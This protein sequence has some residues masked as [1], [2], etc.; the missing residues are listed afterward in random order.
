MKRAPHALIG[1]TLLLALFISACN[2][3]KEDD[4]NVHVIALTNILE[5]GRAAPNQAIDEYQQYLV[6]NDVEISLAIQ[7]YEVSTE[8]MSEV[9]YLSKHQ[10]V[11]KRYD[12]IYDAFMGD[13]PIAEGKLRRITDEVSIP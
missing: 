13:F 5:E 3:D 1:L 8:K 11:F 2:S 10:P 7:K 6:D 4:I 12:V 9:D